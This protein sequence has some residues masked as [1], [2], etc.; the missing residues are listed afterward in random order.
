MGLEDIFARK[1]VSTYYKKTRGRADGLLAFNTQNND[2]YTISL[3]AKSH[4][5]FNS[6]CT[7]YENKLY[8]GIG[9]LILILTY[10]LLHLILKNSGI[11]LKWFVPGLL[12]IALTFI[13]LFVF[14]YF[15]LFEGHG[16]IE[17]VRR[18]PANEK[19]IAF[20]KDAINFYNK[21]DDNELL[22]RAKKYGIGVLA[23]STKQK[24]EVVLEAKEDKS[25]KHIDYLKHYITGKKI[26]ESLVN[27]L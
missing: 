19:W 26:R 14:Q 6:L 5:T 24:I 20:S 25:S 16:I 12:S 9:F 18:Y 10:G 8:F 15:A 11:F 7:V 4:K 1:E 3:E 13:I 21:L 22:F 23:V 27:K 17:Q 2:V